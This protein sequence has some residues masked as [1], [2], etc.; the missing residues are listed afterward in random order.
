MARLAMDGCA[1]MCKCFLILFNILFALV[2][3]GLVALGMWLRFG[4]ET[5]GFFDIDLSTTQFNIGVMV[6]VVTGVLMLLVAIIGDCGACNNSKSA[7][8]VFSGLL[9]VLI[10]IEIAAGVMAFMWSD[11]VS[12]ELV[13]FY[14]TIYAQYLK[15]RSPAQAVTLE[16]FNNAFDCCGVGGPIE[17]FVRD[18]C[19][20]GSFLQQLSYSSCPSMIKDVFNSNA[21]LV[22]GG[23]LGTAGIMT[24]ALVCSCVLRRHVSVSHASPPAYVLLTSPPSVA[25]MI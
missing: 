2:G 25:K 21:Q 23:F 6:L 22:L 8:G 3:L 10:I 20:K 4:A 15:T 14:A 11:R 1:Q 17:M 12:G 5:R 24:L 18:T 7:L 9:T 13:N 19:P 16:L